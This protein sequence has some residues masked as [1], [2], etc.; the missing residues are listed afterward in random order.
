MKKFFTLTAGFMYAAS[1]CA[2]AGDYNTLF[3]THADSS[4]T[5]ITLSDD[6]EI[7]FD[8]ANLIA[9]S[10]NVDVSVSRDNI[11]SF[12]HGKNVSAESPS[13]LLRIEY[14]SNRLHIAGIE[15]RCILSVHDTSGKCIV[16]ETISG[17]YTL[18]MS[19]FATGAYVVSVADRKYK[20]AVK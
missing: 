7:H 3:I 18:D 9:S 1:I 12:R 15:G 16:N 4:E 5:A 20:I 11:L 2:M 17:D 14:S 19:E 10:Q 13:A 8:E 6:L